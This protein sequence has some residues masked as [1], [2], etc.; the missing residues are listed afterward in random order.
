MK[1]IIFILL[2]GTAFFNHL[3]NAQSPDEVY[4]RPLSEVLSDIEKEFGVILNYSSSIEDEIVEFA[5]WKITFNM[6]TTLDNVL[7]PLGLDYKKVYG[8]RNRFEI[9]PYRYYERSVEEGKEHLESLLVLYGD[10]GE[11]ENRK[12]ALRTHIQDI[13]GFDVSA[14]RDPVKAIMGKETK[15]D[16]YLVQNV[17]IESIP[18]YYVTG[19]LYKPKK[20]KG[21]FPVILSPHGH[22]YNEDN[23]S[24]QMDSGRYR[25]DMQIRCATLAQMGAMVLSYDMYAW[26]E[27]IRQTGSYK[28]HETGFALRIQTWNSIRALDFMLS[29]QNANKDKVG[30]TGA[31]GGGTQ[32]F[33]LGALDDRVTASVPTIMVS[34]NFYGGC[35]CE[36]GLPIHDVSDGHNT[37]NVE[38]AALMSPKPQLVISEGCDWTTSFPDI[39]YPYL[40]K[41]YGFFGKAENVQ[42][43]HLPDAPIHDYSYPKR[44]PMYHFFAENLGLKL[45]AVQD[46]GGKIDES[47]CT[48]QKHDDLLV[49]G[50]AD[51]P[52][53]ALRSHDAIVSKFNSYLSND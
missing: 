32:T 4:K 23:P 18:G 31:S 36:S 2:M 41:V 14:K 6:A 16:G 21:P 10:Q 12:L 48:I 49:F 52:K 11:F 37:N 42:N 46:A 40:K 3:V 17:A 39:D 43:F 20:G 35:P 7:K 30:V 8:E 47:Y 9:F 19:T 1:K 24:I 29:L 45:K 50:I 44:E 53:N 28:F 38:L 34:S 25:V 22:F 26:G 51:L 13:V 33:L 5:N 15:M 27:S